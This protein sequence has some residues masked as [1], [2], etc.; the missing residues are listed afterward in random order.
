MHHTTRAVAAANRGGDA[1]L[2]ATFQEETTPCL[3]T[4]PTVAIASCPA[5][6]RSRPAPSPCRVTRSS[7]SPSPGPFPGATVSRGS[8][9]TSTPRSGRRTA[10]CGVEPP[11]PRPFLVRR[12]RGVQR[13]LSRLL[14]DWAILVGDDNP[15]PRTNVAPV[16]ARAF[17][18][19]ALRLRLHGARHDARTRRSSSPAP[20]RCATA[21][22]GRRESCRHGDTSPD[23]MR[24]KARFVMGVMQDPAPGARRGLGPRDGDRRL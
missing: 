8:T 7:T 21:R 18:A 6:A 17:R 10:L 11:S 24:D 3:S 5:S 13:R 9:A 15:I 20:A 12:L 16:A 4:A 19:R 14:K 23:G 1:M 2:C 22:K